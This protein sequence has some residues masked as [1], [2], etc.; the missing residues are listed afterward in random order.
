LRA[1]AGATAECPECHGTVI[2][3]GHLQG[4]ATKRKARVNTR[5][6]L[7]MEIAGFLFLVWYPIGTIIGPILVFFG[8]RKNNS[9]RCSNCDE[10]T[11]TAATKCAKCRAAFS[12]E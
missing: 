11:T 8:W 4:V 1:D 3:P 2:L 12:S 10:P 5:L 6:G 9:L 7:A